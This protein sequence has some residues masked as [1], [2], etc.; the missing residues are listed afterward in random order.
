MSNNNENAD[1]TPPGELAVGPHIIDPER[2]EL[3]ER[4]AEAVV[5]SA[6]EPVTLE[7]LGER[8]PR[9]IDPADIL[10]R[11]EERY[12]NRGIRLMRISGGWAFQT[13]PDLAAALTVERVEQKK[14]TRAQ[15][16]TM[17]IIAYHQPITRP[18][19]EEIRGVSLSKGVLDRLLDLGWVRPGRR[20]DAPGRPLTF[21][22][23]PE[24]LKHFGLDTVQDLPGAEELAAMGLLDDH[25]GIIADFVQ[26]EDELDLPEPAASVDPDI[27][28][29]E[30]FGDVLSP[31]DEDDGR[32]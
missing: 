10:A 13:A 26:R 19:M 28:E 30:V 4:L 14:L 31:F 3:A 6:A 17:A 8:M 12:R 18:E 32:A 1:I 22:T 29:A 23:T 20:R 15:V 16:E 5:F 24:F 27:D 11:L 21:V 9:G 25:S 7:A 2:A